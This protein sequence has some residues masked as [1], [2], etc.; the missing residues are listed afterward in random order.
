MS[1]KLVTPVILPEQVQ[2]LM[3]TLKHTNICF[4][5]NPLNS[6]TRIL[7]AGLTC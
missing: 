1:L 2:S 3:A 4:F 7:I 6:G 5:H